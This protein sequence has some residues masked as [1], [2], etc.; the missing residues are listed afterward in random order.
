MNFPTE[1]DKHDQKFDT[2]SPSMGFI[3]GEQARKFFLQ[4]GLPPSVLAEI[5]DEPTNR[6]HR[7]QASDAHGG[8]RSATQR[9][10]GDAPADACWRFERRCV[11]CCYFNHC[12]FLCAF[13]KKCVV[14]R[15]FCFCFVWF[16]DDNF[17]YYSSHT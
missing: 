2:L 6:L 4:S 1:R 3:S 16:G 14:I 13:M 7:L 12:F 15:T 11:I 10:H 17:W 9:H 8:E 5:W